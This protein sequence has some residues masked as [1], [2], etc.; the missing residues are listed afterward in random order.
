MIAIKDTESKTKAMDAEMNVSAV[1]EMKVKA[2]G[3]MKLMVAA[4]EA[5]TGEVELMLAGT[6]IMAA[7]VKAMAGGTMVMAVRTLAR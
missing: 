4:T 3:D 7:M 6:V 2:E 1:E 5:T